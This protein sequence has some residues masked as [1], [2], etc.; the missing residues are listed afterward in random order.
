MANTPKVLSI[1][2][3]YLGH[4]TYGHL[5]RTHFAQVSACNVD[6]CWYNDDREIHTRIL[7]RLLS[8]V[9][10]NSWL[11]DQNLTAHLLR[12]QLG[13][14]YMARRLALRKLKQSRYSVLHFHT[15]PLAYLSLDLM[16]QWPT[17]VSLDRT[18]MQVAREKSYP[19]LRWTYRP[20]FEIEKRV[21]QSAAAIVSFSESARQSVLQDY[22]INPHKVRVIYPGVNLAQIPLRESTQ[23]ATRKPFN[24]LFIGGDFDRKGGHDLLEVFLEEFSNDAELHLV[25]TA[26]VQC[27]H[28]NVHIHYQIEAYTPKWLQLYHQA[29]VFVM[30]TYSEPFG[31]VFIEAMAAGLPIVTTTI[32]AIPEIVCHQETGLLIQSGDRPAL[33]ESLR[34]LMH[35]PQLRSDMGFRARQLAEQKFNVHKNFQTLESLF[36]E[37]SVTPDLPIQNLKSKIQNVI[38]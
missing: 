24:I 21:F 17:V 38:P 13:F 23:K 32:N 33:A 31:W 20:H 22:N 14:A 12:I 29:D 30:P 34:I 19:Q 37:V 28:P 16:E 11:R 1:I 27:D 2:E 18:I 9:P 35:N 7:N 4:K 8:Y 5:M 6:F 15:Q 25:T 3:E 26:S 10:T 36:R